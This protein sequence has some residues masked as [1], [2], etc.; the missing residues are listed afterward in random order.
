MVG[1]AWNSAG[2]KV[3]GGWINE[4]EAVPEPVVILN[5]D[6]KQLH[7]LRD[8]SGSGYGVAFLA[9]TDALLIGADRLTAVNA[10][11]G[12][13]LWT[14]EIGGAQSFAFSADGKIGAAGGWGRKAGKFNPADGKLLQSAAFESVIGGVALL[15]NGDLAIA[16][17]GGTKPLSVLRGGADKPEPLF[18][19]QFAFQNVL[20]SSALRALV[21]AEQGGRLWLLSA[22]GKP[23]AML[24]EDAG[25]TAFRL[26]E[27]EGRLLVS[28][29]NR[30]IQVIATQ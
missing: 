11:T 25:T 19:S 13:I 26:L 16:A 12:T 30:E 5:S 15:P 9:D 7:A 17:W 28:R 6:G 23:Q 21:A 10:E 29:M 22:D 24:D 20:W 27:H 8:I 2:T 14:N 4:K 1:V 18:Q 3:A